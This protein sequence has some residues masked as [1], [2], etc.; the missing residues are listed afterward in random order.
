[1][2]AILN[3]A[4]IEALQCYRTNIKFLMKNNAKKRISAI[5]DFCKQNTNETLKLINKTWNEF[6][7]KK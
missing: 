2:A 1:M 6:P 4:T 5:L 7:V 3:C